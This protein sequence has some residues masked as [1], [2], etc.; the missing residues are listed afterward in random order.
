[1]HI[2]ITQKPQIATDGCK[3]TLRLGCGVF[4]AGTTS[5]PVLSRKVGAV[6]RKFAGIGDGAQLHSSSKSV[7]HHGFHPLEPYIT[8]RPTSHRPLPRHALS[9]NLPPT[10]ASVYLGLTLALSTA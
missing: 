4:L 5:Q 9:P 10:L 1:M 3:G 7:A 2:S 6:V 8:A